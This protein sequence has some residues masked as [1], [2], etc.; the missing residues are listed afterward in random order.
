MS[1][2]SSQDLKLVSKAIGPLPIINRFVERM[3]LDHFFDQFVPQQDRRLKLAPAIGLGVLL[4]NILVSRQPVY[5]LSEWAHR[6]DQPLL[7]LPPDDP[8]IL[9]DDRIGRCLDYL[10]AADRAALMTAIVVHTVRTFDVDLRELHNDST[11]VTFTGQYAR[12]PGTAARGGPAHRIT[13]GHNKDHRPDLKQLLWVLT[14]SADGTVPVWCNVDHGNTTDD[15]TH[16]DTWNVLRRLVGKSNFLYVADSKLCTKQNMEHIAREQGRFITVLPKTRR[17]DSWFRDWLQSHDPTWLELLRSPNARKKDGPDQVYRGFESPLR[18]VEGYRIVWIWSSQKQEQDRAIRQGRIQQAI[19]QLEQLRARLTSPRPR[20]KTRAQVDKAAQSILRETHAERWITVEVRTVEEHRYRQAKSGRPS[21]NTAY[22]RKTQERPQLHWKSN[23]EMLQYDDRT[24]GIFPLVTNDE[25]MSLR[26][27]L[28]AYKH[29][30]CIEKRHEQL[31]S[32]LDVMPVNLKSPSRIEA[33]LFIYF[34]ALL[35]S[36]LIEREIRQQMKTEK[37]P[38]LPLYPEQ[39]PCKAPTA[40]RIF[41]LFDDVRRHR[42]VAADASV[43]KR[44]YD[45]LTQLQRT[46]LPLCGLSP[47]QYLRAGEER[48]GPSV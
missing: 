5:G 21:E 6:F 42:L 29:Q 2:S 13:F 37:I 9:N 40:N 28:V 38:S 14:T 15:R 1:S 34:L 23:A 26:D 11:T 32:V 31:K 19:E 12:A 33:F 30:P 41:E 36:S 39:R 35:V 4:R 25:A 10:F 48:A 22:V 44:F 46:V 17:E 16:I 24:D 27:V 8:D 47:A 18:S 45:E 3:R 20:L 43:Q 7:G